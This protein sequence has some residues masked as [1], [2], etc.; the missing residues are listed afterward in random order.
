MS[1]KKKLFILFLAFAV[2]G[3]SYFFFASVRRDREGGPMLSIKNL[4]FGNP[5]EVGQPAPDFE[6]RDLAGRLIR[7]SDLRGKVVFLNIW[8]TWCPPC[9]YEMPM[10]EKL[11]WIMRG[12]SFIV[13]AASQDTGGDSEEN[14]RKFVRENG[15]TFTILL[16]PDNQLSWL[17]RVIGLP[18]TFIIDKDGILVQRIIG[19]KD[20]T[21]P[22]WVAAMT[23]LAER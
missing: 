4:M 15:L 1:L 6:L 11:H 5:P 10:I 18:E 3:F 17:Y 22:E 16:D 21:S 2:V 23:Q 20:W 19:P 8:A 14:V 9:V 13:L 12:R 7:L